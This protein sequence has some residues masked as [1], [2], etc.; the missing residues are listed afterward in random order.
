MIGYR[1]DNIKYCAQCDETEEDL[2]ATGL[3]IEK[4]KEEPWCETRV[5]TSPTQCAYECRKKHSGI[6]PFFDT[7]MGTNGECWLEKPNDEEDC[8]KSAY[9][10]EG[11]YGLYL[12]Q[13][14]GND[15]NMN[16]IQLLKYYIDQYWPIS[17]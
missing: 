12:V 13:N 6:C 14:I 10:K 11:P 7:K 9:Q 3:T 4:I 2:V 16:S 1:I 15:F 5:E 17:I 8:N